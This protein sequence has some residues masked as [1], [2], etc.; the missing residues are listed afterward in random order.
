MN[1]TQLLKRLD[2]RWLAFL[3]SFSGLSDKSLL[4]PGVTA[5]WSVRDLMA[6]VTTWEREALKAMPLIL[7]GKP[8]PRYASVGGID[9]FNAREQERKG[10]AS[11]HRVKQGLGATHGRLVAFLKGVP[12]A[13]YASE[14]RFVKRLRVDTYGHYREHTKHILAWRESQNL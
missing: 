6:H 4:T 10:G 11:L 9:A 5:A 8:L 7:A 1:Q 2:E 13:A 14:G 3:T 12:P